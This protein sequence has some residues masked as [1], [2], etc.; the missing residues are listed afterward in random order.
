LTP[1]KCDVLL[2]M[3]IRCQISHT[4]FQTRAESD[5]RSGTTRAF[6]ECT[7]ID[8]VSFNKCSV[9]KNVGQNESRPAQSPIH[10]VLNVYR[11]QCTQSTVL[12]CRNVHLKK[13]YLA[14]ISIYTVTLNHLCIYTSREHKAHLKL[15]PFDYC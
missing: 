12:L 9:H 7:A 14:E 1:R 15:V 5:M 8:V 11:P 3:Q 2:P 4:A 10:R 13:Q 6:T